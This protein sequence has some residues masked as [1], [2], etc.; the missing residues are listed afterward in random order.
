M[1][2]KGGTHTVEIAGKVPVYTADGRSPPVVL[3][4]DWLQRVMRCRIGTELLM[5]VVVSG[6]MSGL[7]RWR[8]MRRRRRSVSHQRRVV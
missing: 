5:S 4:L 1:V 3:V 2:D 6:K 8:C 7:E